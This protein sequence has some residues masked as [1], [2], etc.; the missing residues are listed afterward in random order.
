MIALLK[1]FVWF[2]NL[3]SRQRSALTLNVIHELWASRREECIPVQ[4]IGAQRC[5]ERLAINGFDYTNHA[6]IQISGPGAVPWEPNCVK[7]NAN[8]NYQKEITL[9]LPNGCSNK[10]LQHFILS[11]MSTLPIPICPMINFVYFV[12]W[13]IFTY[14]NNNNMTALFDIIENIFSLQFDFSN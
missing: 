14:I 12:W 4:A 13:I 7:L 6:S 11:F 3:L 1:T 8:Y 10:R 2:T 5:S 9:S